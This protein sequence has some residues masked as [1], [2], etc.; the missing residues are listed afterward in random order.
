LQWDADIAAMPPPPHMEALPVTLS[1]M[2]AGVV[3][4]MRRLPDELT[5]AVT[6]AKEGT[7]NASVT[8]KLSTPPQV[9]RFLE[10]LAD[11]Q[12]HPEWLT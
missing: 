1:G 3:A 4:D 2:G 6:A 11:V 12:A 9:S 10:A 7:R 5:R 8:L